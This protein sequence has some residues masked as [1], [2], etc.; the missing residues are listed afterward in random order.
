MYLKNNT[1]TQTQI[2]MTMTLT[3]SNILHKNDNFL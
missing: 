2:L 1:L 3:L